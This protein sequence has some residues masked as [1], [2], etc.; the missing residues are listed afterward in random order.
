MLP[1]F[2]SPPS[3]VSLTIFSS[4]P[5]GL[6]SFPFLLPLAHSLRCTERSTPGR[7]LCRC[8]PRRSDIKT[9]LRPQTFAAPLVSSGV[10]FPSNAGR[11]RGVDVVARPPS[12]FRLSTSG[13]FLFPECLPPTSA[14]RNTASRSSCY[15]SH[16]PLP[17]SLPPP[18]S[19]SVSL[20]L[21]LPIAVSLSLLLP[22]SSSA[23]PSSRGI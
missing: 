8:L 17:L 3:P 7:Y 23:R 9:L 18:R 2:L 14:S 21:C 12:S 6:E 11:R 5:Q 4:S 15:A 1:S 10:E 13:Y 19:L 16:F 20:Y 22:S